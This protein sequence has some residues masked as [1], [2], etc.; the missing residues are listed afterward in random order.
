MMR[1]GVF[2]A[3][4]GFLLA[5]PIALCNGCGSKPILSDAEKLQQVEERYADFKSRFPDVRDVSVAELIALQERRPLV[6]VDVRPANERQE[7]M[8]PTAVSKD[9]F[10]KHRDQYRETL[11]VTYCTIGARSG[12]YAAEIQTDGF[13]VVNLRGSILA[14]AHAG[15]SLV[16]QRGPTKRVHVYG[17]TWDLLPAGFEAVW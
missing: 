14:W 5:L 16:D 9:L 10:E 3:A 7:S 2:T 13:E 15:Q 12:L 4:I 1:T 8:I 17:P 6:I 11:V